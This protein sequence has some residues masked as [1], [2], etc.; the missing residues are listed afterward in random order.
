MP[1]SNQQSPNISSASR[2]GKSEGHGRTVLLVEDDP[3]IGRV[4]EL[5]LTLGGL[6]VFRAADGSDAMH[7]LEGAT[8]VAAIVDPGLPDGLGT[9]VLK[10]LN[11][12]R[13]PVLVLSALDHERAS[14]IYSITREAFMSKPFDPNEMVAEVQR[15]M[16]ATSES[17][18]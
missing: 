10:R 15:L 2:R 4:A 6:N 14:V 9:H 11:E 7:F 17:D 13:V 8:P 12:Q 3:G 16:L 5:A 18:G 1:A